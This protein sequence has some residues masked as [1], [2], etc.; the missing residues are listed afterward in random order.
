MTDQ[1]EGT[2]KIHKTVVLGDETQ[3]IYELHIKQ[4][5]TVLLVHHLLLCFTGGIHG[6]VVVRWT[7]GQ[8]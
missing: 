8:Q 1:V 3:S 5:G 2:L 6:T 7:A 4:I